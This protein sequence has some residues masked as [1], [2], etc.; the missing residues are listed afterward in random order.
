MLQMKNI[1]WTLLILCFATTVSAKE[2]AALPISKST[3][4]AKAYIISPKNGEV[5]T[6]PVKVVFGLT[7]MGIA[8]A[9]VQY[10]ESGHH[11]LIIDAPLPPPGK[12]IP[13][14]E[15]H[16]HFG[17]GQTETK[18]ELKPGK[19]TL[20]LILGDHLHLPHDPVV[21]SEKIEITVK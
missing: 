16:I 6:S 8:P 5:V 20:Q 1:S 2:K 4:G 10:P 18:I 3:Q 13:A 14:D 11:H 21:A 7:Q 9:G 19:H 17:K 12:P 15:K